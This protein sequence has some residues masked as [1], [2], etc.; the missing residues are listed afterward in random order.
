MARY[1]KRDVFN[2]T[3]L[4]NVIAPD[5]TI[6]DVELSD[7][8]TDDID[9]LVNNIRQ[10]KKVRFAWVK[11]D[12][13]TI[14]SSPDTNASS[15]NELLKELG[16]TVKVG[17]K[18]A[19]R[20]ARAFSPRDVVVE[21][22]SVN[23][24]VVPGD[25]FTRDPDLFNDED[26][27]ALL[28]GTAAFSKSFVHK[29]M[30]AAGRKISELRHV[31]ALSASMLFEGGMLKV[32]AYIVDDEFMNGADIICGGAN[33]KS[34]L[35]SNRIWM[36]FDLFRPFGAP[37]TNAQL[38]PMVGRMLHNE[39]I[40]TAILTDVLTK[41]LNR[42]VSG[43]AAKSLE[44]WNMGA[45]NTAANS[46]KVNQDFAA[47]SDMTADMAARGVPYQVFP[48]MMSMLATAGSNQYWSTK[49]T[50]WPIYPLICAWARPIISESAACLIGEETDVE[51]GEIRAI[52]DGDVWVVNDQD[53]IEFFRLNTGGSDL[54]DHFVLCFRMI[55]GVKSVFI[56][57]NPM[58]WREF[59]VLKFVEGDPYP[60][61]TK[62]DGTDI[63]FPVLPGKLTK[64]LFESI[65]DGESIIRGLDGFTPVEYPETYGP[66]AL[67]PTMIEL[68]A[69][70]GGF[71][72]A[73]INTITLAAGHNPKLLE[74]VMAEMETIIDTFT[75]GGATEVRKALM[76]WSESIFDR[77]QGS[78][79][80]DMA[81]W[82][83]RCNGADF[84]GTLV[85]GFF[86]RRRVLNMS[87]RKNFVNSVKAYANA[88]ASEDHDL[89]KRLEVIFGVER[90]NV[91]ITE[92]PIMSKAAAMEL[93]F[94]RSIAT[95]LSAARAA[96]T[97]PDWTRLYTRH[98]ERIMASANGDATLANVMAVAS[99][100]AAMS[101]TTQ[102]GIYSDRSIINTKV[103]PM[104]IQGMVDLGL[105]TDLNTMSNTIGWTLT[106]NSC[107][108]E[109][110]SYNA[111]V[112]VQYLWNNKVC[113]NCR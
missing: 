47:L 24:V 104:F 61:Y 18:T 68:I 52:R 13:L 105:A 101:M 44:D 80:M 59:Q 17:P 92:D 56:V 27:E 83:R 95:E 112:Y 19:K 90:K 10:S 32:L 77:L 28:D 81:L 58:G 76:E 31:E 74:D 63:E 49:G 1:I 26:K 2:K 36:S 33:I 75:Q 53:Y 82:L 57:R 91:R 40:D 23:L 111:S 89:I 46:T 37:K 55:N 6:W 67:I 106:C 7:I 110:Q 85:K 62:A 42:I 12:K 94:R 43:E 4:I 39:A 15:W 72:G 3:S 60:V 66:E 45:L 100:F 88:R 34:D 69:G 41:D 11:G 51:R 65:R 113:R 70:E 8:K 48:G 22:K 54:D 5:A 16:I 14:W 21:L 73:I 93:I 9:L 35:S 71:V 25:E 109:R 86:S 96:N 29:M 97:E 64:N 79:N 38:D 99:W 102:A 103:W 98:A 30:R 20:F 50:G 107:G 78:E 87:I 108:A 84:N